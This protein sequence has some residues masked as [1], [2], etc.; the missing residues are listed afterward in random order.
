[1]EE[2]LFIATKT[3]SCKDFGG[4]WTGSL[5]QNKKADLIIATKIRS[6][7]RIFEK[8][9]SNDAKEQFFYFK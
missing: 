8:S 2:R 9:T 6:A 5:V 1:M 3:E 4:L 7:F